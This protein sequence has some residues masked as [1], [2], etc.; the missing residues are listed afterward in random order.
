MGVLT[1]SSKFGWV[2]TSQKVWH[3]PCPIEETGG[4]HTYYVKERESNPKE[5]R[6]KPPEPAYLYPTSQAEQYEKEIYYGLLQYYSSGSSSSCNYPYYTPYT[7]RY[8]NR[9]GRTTMKTQFPSALDWQTK[10]RLDIKDIA[11]NLGV[12]LVEYRQ[13]A[14]MFRDFAVGVHGAWKAFRGRLPKRRRITPCDIAASELVYSYGIEPLAKDL[15]DSYWQLQGRLVDPVYRRFVS[16][17]RDRGEHLV[18]EFAGKHTCQWEMSQRA[19]A[20]V[21]METNYSDFKLGNPLELAWE[22]IP[23]SFVVDWA[24]PVG[25]YLSALDALKDVKS[26][27]GTVTTRKKTKEITSPRE[28]YEL[29]REV[30]EPHYRTLASHKRDVITSI[31]LPSAPVYDPSRSWRAIMHGLS[32]LTQLNRRCSGKPRYR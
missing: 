29:G 14:R 23:F 20:Y 22:V 6:T 31:P 17:A 13:T 16:T 9:F 21:Q 7:T 12:T 1:T 15:Y 2:T 26:V 4:N 24:V 19:I 25:D 28:E 27:I 3:G 30:I 32:L 10:M 5:S 11:V 18:S 8:R